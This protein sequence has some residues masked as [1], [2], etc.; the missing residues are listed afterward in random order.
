MALPGAPVKPYRAGS[1]PILWLGR[2]PD[3]WSLKRVLPQKLC[4]F[5]PKTKI[6]VE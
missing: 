2:C 3:V 1:T 4:G 5:H 6:K